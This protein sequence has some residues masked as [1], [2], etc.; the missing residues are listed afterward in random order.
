MLNGLAFQ[1]DYR[2]RTLRQHA[3]AEILLV[4]RASAGGII[5]RMERQGWIA[6]EVDPEDSRAR[7]VSLTAAGISKLKE[8]RAPY[9][10]LLGRLVRDADGASLGAL[11]DLLDVIRSRLPPPAPR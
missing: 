5:A 6:R 3:L 7:R 1:W 4:N 11:V 2:A 10:A 9:Y 8:V